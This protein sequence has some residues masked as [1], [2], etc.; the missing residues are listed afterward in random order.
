MYRKC[1]QILPLE[2][3]WVTVGPQLKVSVIAESRKMSFF[4]FGEPGKPICSLASERVIRVLGTVWMG[5]RYE[6]NSR[7]RSRLSGRRCLELSLKT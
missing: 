6:G 5:H 3:W 7:G 4:L 1:N 2:S